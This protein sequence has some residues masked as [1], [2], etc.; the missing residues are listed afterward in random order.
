MDTPPGVY[1]QIPGL[2]ESGTP[3][4][5]VVVTSARGSTPQDAGAKMIVTAAGLHAGT[6]GGGKIE[7]RAIGHAQA[8]LAGGEATATVEWNLRRDVGMT[9]GGVMAL[10]FE[11]HRGSEWTIAIFG[12][13]HVAQAL[14]PVLARL[15]C[16][17]LC[18][19]PR[20]EWLA[21]L[22]Q[23]SN[24]RA[25]ERAILEDAV[26]DLPDGAYVLLMT[27]GHAT[28]F[29]IL[30]RILESRSFPYVGVIGSRSKR[31]ALEGELRAAGVPAE[32]CA[33][34]ECPAG[35]PIGTNHPQE[36]AISIAAG[37]LQARDRAAAGAQSTR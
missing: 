16:Q 25:I 27:Q 34:F 11:V 28:D 30:R 4:V 31:A 32:K 15:P 21:R 18:L 23:L 7:T 13:G 5:L 14:A 6:V 29:P 1:D 2:I 8:M 33:A 17:I 36:I 19:D 24:V 26:A 9:C 22:P 12:A 35:L 20:P 10:F 37:I 3:F